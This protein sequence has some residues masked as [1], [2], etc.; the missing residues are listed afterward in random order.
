MRFDLLRSLNLPRIPSGNRHGARIG[1]AGMMRFAGAAALALVVL[2]LTI[3]GA[4]AQIVTPPSPPNHVDFGAYGAGAFDV[5][6][7]FLTRLGNRATYGYD[8]AARANPDGGGAP[9]SNGGVKW[10]SW[11]EAYATHSRQGAQGAFVGDTRRTF[12]GVAGLSATL[13]EHLTI[14]LSVDQSHTKVNVPLALQSATLDMTQIGL[15]AAYTDGPWTAAVAIVQGFADISSRRFDVVGFALANYDARLTGAL[16]EISYYH[17]FGQSRLVPKAAL[18]W[19][20]IKTD[21]FGEVG[22]AAPLTATGQR[23]SR[24]RLYLGAEI[25]HYWIVEQ[26]IV[27]LSAYAKFVDTLQQNNG[28]ISVSAGGPSLTVQGVSESQYGVNAGTTLSVNFTQMVRA[29]LAYDGKFRDGFTSH[30]GTA[31]LDV[32]W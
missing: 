28:A 20:E 16:G 18:E 31:G 19:L 25:G 23:A 22:G 1:R 7:N 5:G 14:G 6:S 8:A 10:R 2:G 15:N 3:A 29:Y 21:P 30:T 12:G 26:K 32:S 13:N 11:L 9:D 27:D 4:H 17:G 24:T